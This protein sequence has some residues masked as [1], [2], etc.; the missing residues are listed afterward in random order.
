MCSPSFFSPEGNY[1]LKTTLEGQN[2][3]SSESHHDFLSGIED[4]KEFDQPQS[5][6]KKS[7]EK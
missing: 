2:N 7:T 3:F 5:E 1:Q 4:W 6:N